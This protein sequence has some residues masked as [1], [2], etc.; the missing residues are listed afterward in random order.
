MT[1]FGNDISV[2]QPDIPITGLMSAGSQFF[3][4]RCSKGEVADTEFAEHM[5]RVKEQEALFAAYHFMYSGRVVSIVKQAQIIMETVPP[6]VPIWL[7]LEKSTAGGFPSYLDALSLRAELNS[8]FRVVAGIY[9]PQWYWSDYI[10]SPK[11]SGWRALWSSRYIKGYQKGS[12]KGLYPGDESALWDQYGGMTPLFAQY[13]SSAVLPGYDANTV[14]ADA[15]RGSYAQ[16]TALNQ[17]FHNFEAQ[18]T[19]NAKNALAVVDAATRGVKA[20]KGARQARF[21]EILDIAKELL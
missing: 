9:L 10:G 6:F 14:D 17:L 13:T 2:Y 7:D 15:F 4:A 16:L 1:V 12:I 18:P 19:R 5:A 20:T 21:Q 11:L 8:H 3:V